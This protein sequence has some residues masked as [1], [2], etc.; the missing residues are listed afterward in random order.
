MSEGIAHIVT[1]GSE[2]AAYIGRPISGSAL[3][4][5]DTDQTGMVHTQL[6][7]AYNFP[8]VM[9]AIAIGLHFGVPAE[10]IKAAIETY[11]PS[12]NRS[13]IEKRGS[14]TFI[15]DAYNANPSSMKSR[16]RELR[17]HSC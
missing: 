7:G 8:N 17:S 4:E 10:K 9:A 16:R 2:Q 3:L 12:N 14:N 11:I 5:L 13:Q 1:Y 15:M 6:V